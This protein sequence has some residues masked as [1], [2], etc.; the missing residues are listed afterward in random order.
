MLLDQNETILFVMKLYEIEMVYLDNNVLRGVG[1]TNIR[2]CLRKRRLQIPNDTIEYRTIDGLFYLFIHVVCIFNIHIYSQSNF[3][4]ISKILTV[5]HTSYTTAR[6]V[7]LNL[8]IHF[9]SAH[10]NNS[11]RRLKRRKNLIK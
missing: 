11:S 9:Q 7:R 2:T 10:M 1:P 4:P 5:V 3:L 8:K 6:N